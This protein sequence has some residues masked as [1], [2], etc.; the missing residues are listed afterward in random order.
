MENIT[1]DTLF[2]KA[3][4]KQTEPRRCE[5]AVFRHPVIL[6]ASTVPCVRARV[7]VDERSERVDRRAVCAWLVIDPDYAEGEALTYIG[8]QRTIVEPCQSDDLDV[9]PTDSHLIV[10][11]ENEKRKPLSGFKDA[12]PNPMAILHHLILLTITIIELILGCVDVELCATCKTS[13]AL[14]REVTY[15]QS[16]STVTSEP[17]SLS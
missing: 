13:R 10:K 14:G 12:Q 8:E 16:T 11:N 1:G 2:V 5:R 4:T 3:G 17:E 15:C 7:L 6:T 9:L